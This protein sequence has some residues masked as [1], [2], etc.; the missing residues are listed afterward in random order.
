MTPHSR[1]TN[2]L[3]GLIVSTLAVLFLQSFLSPTSAQTVF[4]G[5]IAG[6]VAMLVLQQTFN[7][8][9]QAIEYKLVPA[10]SLDQSALDQFGKE[11]WRLICAAQD[12][13][14][15]IFAR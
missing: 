4:L 10:G 5:V 1:A 6:L 3:L 12:G 2:V 11:G 14:G 15:Y 7:S 8:A 13:A 9:V